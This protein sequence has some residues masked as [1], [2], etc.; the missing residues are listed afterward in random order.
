MYVLLL[1]PATILLVFWFSLFFFTTDEDWIAA[2][3]GKILENREQISKLAQK[4]IA[5]Q[6]KRDEYAQGVMKVLASILYDDS[7]KKDIERLRKQNR[8]LQGGNLK[9]IGIFSIPGYVLQRKVQVIGKGAFHKKITEQCI[10][11]Y[12]KKYGV[13]WANRELAQ[14]LS[15]PILGLGLIVALSVLFLARD[16]QEMGLILLI[17]GSL[18]MSVLVYMI[19]D[20]VT[21]HI[22]KRR[23]A[24]SRQFPNVVSK[25]ALLVTSG[26]V[27]DRAWR[28]TAESSDREL[29]QE[30]RKTADELDNLVPPAEA[31]SNFILRCNTKETT[32]LAS[33]IIQNLTMGNEQVG[34]L[35]KTMAH[36]AWM[37]RRHTAKKDSEA[38]N[39]KLMIPSILVF[40]MIL[41][42]IMVPVLLSFSSL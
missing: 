40:V 12:G 3:Q 27:M 20:D 42:M 29:Y 15:Y 24:I 11:L 10:E 38:A 5:N 26:M 34:T 19:Y 25:L 4:D 18:I 39:S 22:N 33:A 9:H 8:E 2:A 17:G 41:V 6:K 14:L 23:V 1:V 13:V 21:D 16:N 37:E 36:E 32:K 31:Y 28:E 35:L 7:A 30:M